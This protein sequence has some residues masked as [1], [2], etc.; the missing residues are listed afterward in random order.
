MDGSVATSGGAGKQL[1]PILE[2]KGMPMGVR[3]VPLIAGPRKGQLPV[4]E[5]LL[6]DLRH[7][8]ERR[9]ELIAAVDDERGTILGTIGI[10]P[11]RDEGGTCYHLTGMEVEPRDAGKGIDAF[12]LEEAGR[13][14][15]AHR[16][17]RLKFG[18]SPLLTHSAWLYVTRFGSRYRWREGPR[19]PD[20]QP[21]PYVSC[22]CDF[23]NPLARSLDLRDEEVQGRSVVEWVGGRPR[24]RSRL[25]YSGPLAVV[26]PDLDG[27]TLVRAREQDPGF[28]ATLYSAFHSLHAHGYGFDWFDRLP[29]AG[30]QPAG[31]YYVMKRVVAL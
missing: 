4:P 25:V 2:S 14:L 19:A 24:I 17:T 7:L 30:G 15:R 3:S 26:L 23:D 12:L 27:Q 6:D 18:T 16:T 21:W 5:A 31:W 9:G 1:M 20:G 8:K 29:A 22:E 13:Y 10:Y 28:I 11:V